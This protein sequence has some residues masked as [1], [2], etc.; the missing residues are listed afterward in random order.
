MVSF[1][2]WE[3]L[4]ATKMSKTVS[5]RVG[6]VLDSFKFRPVSEAMSVENTHSIGAQSSRLAIQPVSPPNESAEAKDSTG[7]FCGFR[8]NTEQS[9]R[10]RRQT[11]KT[12]TGCQNHSGRS[13][14][15]FRSRA[16]NFVAN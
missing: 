14:G 10:Y 4:A 8:G 3:K 6:A 11:N 2:R 1:S 12:K 5:L 7:Q 15:L 16:H 9:L 13:W